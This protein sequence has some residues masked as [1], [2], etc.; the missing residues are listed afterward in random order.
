MAAG[1][2][3]AAFSQAPPPLRPP[4]PLLPA[5]LLLLLLLLLPAPPPVSAQGLKKAASAGLGA[6]S[7]YTKTAAVQ[8]NAAL[9]RL[10]SQ[11]ER[12]TTLFKNNPAAA[13]SRNS[14][15]M[16]GSSSGS[17]S[18]DALTFA[19]SP[20][21]FDARAQRLASPVRDQGACTT[22]TAS[23]LM[24]A[25]EAAVAAALKRDAREKQ[26][27][28]QNFHFCGG[29]GSPGELTG[30]STSV[31]VDTAVK[32]M[33]ERP[34]S[35]ILDRCL[36][37]APSNFQPNC[38]R[39]CNDVDPDLSAGR[40]GFTKL[41]SPM[42][43]QKHIRD[44]GGVI[45]RLDIWSDFKPFFKAS[46]S[47]VY[48]GPSS[49]V[50]QI[51]HSVLLLPNAPAS[52]PPTPPAAPPPPPASGYWIFKNSW[53]PDWGMGGYGKISYD[54]TGTGILSPDDTYGIIFNPIT[55]P[56]LSYRLCHH[57]TRR[58][59]Y[60]TRAPPGTWPSKMANDLQMNLKEL[61]RDNT[62]VIK[63][64]SKP[65][66]A[67]DLVVCDLQ[68]GIPKRAAPC[69]TPT[70]ELACTE[71][72]PPSSVRDVHLRSISDVG[73]QAELRVAWGL[74]KG[75][76]CVR[77]YNVQ[78][79]NIETLKSTKVVI[80]LTNSNAAGSI[81]FKTKPFVPGRPRPVFLIQVVAANKAGASAAQSLSVNTGKVSS[82]FDG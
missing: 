78:I 45:T 3:A 71:G 25:V 17:E 76:A 77:Q 16:C 49:A 2:A 27:S 54:A 40:I 58:E 64:L 36:P 7:V 63:D 72:A 65:L 15:T 1:A 60:I 48:S 6:D 46:R 52:Q 47:G 37:Y 38:D 66:P 28:V 53:G 62:R 61:L 82:V 73:G 81:V 42:E 67:A 69:A 33:G 22:C 9:S 31:G 43:V 21:A 4:A 30:C 55:P 5:L 74:P 13:C 56:R 14:Q 32:G 18:S 44:W 23:A 24:S 75:N 70:P 41:G 51:A 79:L 68:D 35:I 19:A 59:C 20:Q 34:K 11:A 57:P 26:Y 50:F 29:V 8:Q 10:T 80:P 39:K 12:F